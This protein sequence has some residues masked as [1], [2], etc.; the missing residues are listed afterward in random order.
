M[1]DEIHHLKDE[2]WQLRRQLA[3]TDQLLKTSRDSQ[4]PLNEKVNSTV[5]DMMKRGEEVQKLAEDRDRTEMELHRKQHDSLL[6]SEMQKDLAHSVEKCQLLQE[7]IDDK[8]KEINRLEEDLRKKD[9]E[10]KVAMKETQELQTN[11]SMLQAE[12]EEKHEEV[13]KLQKEKEALIRL[14]KTKWERIS[15][16]TSSQTC[17][18]EDMKVIIMTSA[19]TCLVYI[20]SCCLVY[21]A[22]CCFYFHSNN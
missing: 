6:L 10:L 22:S 11:I 20:A 15:N 18:Q 7:V 17:D 9:H 3:E 8:R 1:T 12:L 21:I 16:I 19:Y 13:K 4:V 5:S 14:C 2:L